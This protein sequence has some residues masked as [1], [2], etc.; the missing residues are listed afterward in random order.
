MYVRINYKL[1]LYILKILTDRRFETCKSGMLKRLATG[2]RGGGGG[3]TRAYYQ[4]LLKY[5]LHVAIH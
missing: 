1:F 4:V 3:Y 2:G 5:N